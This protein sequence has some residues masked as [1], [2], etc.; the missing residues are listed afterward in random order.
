MYVYG[1]ACTKVTGLTIFAPHLLG[2]GWERDDWFDIPRSRRQSSWQPSQSKSFNTAWVGFIH[3][4]TGLQPHIACMYSIF[5][6][7]YMTPRAWTKMFLLPPHVWRGPS[8]YAW[9]TEHICIVYASR[10]TGCTPK[11][12]MAPSAVLLDTSRGF[13]ALPFSPS[14]MA[15]HIPH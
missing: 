6:T 7:A 8:P 2:G 4:Q 10:R 11:S 5:R 12:E 9:T 14:V 1:A 3:Q 13:T 15:S